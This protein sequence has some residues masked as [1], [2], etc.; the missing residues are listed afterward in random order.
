MA[1]LTKH[2]LSM[3][4]FSTK[5][6][7]NCKLVQP[8]HSKSVKMKV[9]KTRGVRHDTRRTGRVLWTASVS[10]AFAICLVS[11]HQT[12]TPSNSVFGGVDAS[13]IMSSILNM[14]IRDGCSLV[15][16]S[17]PMN[18]RATNIL[19]GVSSYAIICL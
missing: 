5:H 14:P 19:L 10:L 15:R 2:Q 13:D 18:T 9:A 4:T 16:G 11:S 3:A 7:E 6:H 12:D 8:E 1:R 17:C